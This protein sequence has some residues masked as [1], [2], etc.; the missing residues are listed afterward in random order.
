MINLNFELNVPYIDRWADIYVACGIVTEYKAWEFQ[1]LKTTTL[2]K[3]QVDFRLSGDHAGLRLTLG[4]LGYEFDLNVYDTRH[5]DDE[6]RCW[7]K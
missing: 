1:I 4:L 3:L 5:W 6:N 7:E 2:I